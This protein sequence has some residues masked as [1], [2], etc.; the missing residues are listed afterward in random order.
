[1]LS[2]YVTC[3]KGNIY[4]EVLKQNMKDKHNKLKKQ[5]VS[6]T[7][8]AFLAA[9]VVAVTT[10]GVVSIISKTPDEINV[11]DNL[12]YNEDSTDLPDVQNFEDLLGNLPRV[13][14]IPDGSS[15]V[16]GTAQGITD[17]ISQESEQDVTNDNLETSV[18][19]ENVTEDVDY[20][21]P[22]FVKPCDGYISREFSVDVLTYCPTMSDFRIHEGIDIVCEAATP[23]KAV[24]G[25][26]V[27]D[28]TDDVLYGKVV[29]IQSPDGLTLRYCNLSE[30]LASGVEKDA[31]IQT[32]SV[33]GGVGST[34][35]CE[36][37]QPPHLHLE[38]IRDGQKTNPEELFE[39]IYL[40]ESNDA[41]ESGL[42]D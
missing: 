41:I 40:K 9:A 34:A 12:K 37:A 39:E 24:T 36:A 5:L 2:A 6:G 32:G 26:V 8:Y 15:V 22:G 21:Y 27:T 38:A 13:E 42:V 18:T 28:I 4:K 10:S 29:T 11:P 33:I 19:P 1:M 31:I 23:V 17:E 14:N 16:S 35:I 3:K 20:G 7:V 30:V 25:G